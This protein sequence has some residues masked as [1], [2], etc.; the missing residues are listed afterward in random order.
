MQIAEQIAHLGWPEVLQQVL[1]HEGNGR[2]LNRIDFV[3]GQGQPHV[4]G[5]HE[6]DAARILLGNQTGQQASV[7]RLNDVG[8]VFLTND[9][10]RIHDAG[11]QVIAVLAVGV[12][13]VRPDLIAFAVELVA[14]GAVLE[15]QTST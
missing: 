7:E 1:R 14:D 10:T 12:G 9:G 15:E 8:E 5:V 2:L 11:K 6:C 13:Q 3:A 4:L